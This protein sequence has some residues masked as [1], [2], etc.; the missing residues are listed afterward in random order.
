M[1][2]QGVLEYLDP[3]GSVDPKVLAM[4]M[5]IAATARDVAR[6]IGLDPAIVSIKLIVGQ[7]SLRFRIPDAGGKS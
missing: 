1:K 3:P 4:S 2:N 5:A 6:K 7:D